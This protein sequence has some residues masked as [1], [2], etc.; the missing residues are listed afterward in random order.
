MNKIEIPNSEIEM[1]PLSTSDE[2]GR[3]FS[4]RGRIFRGINPNRELLVNEMFSCGMLDELI[5]KGFIPKIWITDFKT[6]DYSIVLEHEK[7]NFVT[8]PQEWSFSMLKDATILV[9]KLNKLTS[10]YGFQTKDCHGYNI[11]FNGSSPVYVDIGSFVRVG[12]D[13]ENFSYG[14]SYNEFMQFY[15]YPLKIWSDGNS[16]FANA[17]IYYSNISL[18]G[19]DSYLAYKYAFIRFPGKNLIKIV[20]RIANLWAL[21]KMVFV[22]DDNQILGKLPTLG[23]IIIFLKKHYLLP[24][25]LTNFENLIKK[26]E[27]ISAPEFES[28]W[29]DYQ[30]GLCRENNDLVVTPRFQRI[31]DIIKCFDIESITELAGNQGILSG[32]IE[33]NANVKRIFCSDYDHNAVEKMYNRLKKTDST[34]TPGILNFVYPHAHL[35]KISAFERFRADAVVATAI[36]HHLLLTE[37]INIDYMMEIMSRYTNKYI[38]IEFMPLGLWDHAKL[39]A[40]PVPDWYNE[41]TF[42]KYFEKYFSVALKEQLESNRLLFVGIKKRA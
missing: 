19:T 31:I 12:K 23:K 33:Q 38:L 8:Y 9:L 36:T 27:K 39:W 3:V 26:V 16:Y 20:R 41:E 22:A 11:V 4:W 35:G 5:E 29:K 17:V 40:P 34:I 14:S 6:E 37:K 21:Y 32:L 42:K 24:F 7:V 15:Y 13:L 18:M 30:N 1:N 25:N 28:A 2:L 10:K